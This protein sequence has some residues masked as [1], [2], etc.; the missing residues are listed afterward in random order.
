MEE[1]VDFDTTELDGLAVCQML[2]MGY[3]EDVGEDLVFEGNSYRAKEYVENQFK[4]HNLGHIEHEM[5]SHVSCFT[6]DEIH[7]SSYSIIPNEIATAHSAIISPYL[8]LLSETRLEYLMRVPSLLQ[9]AINSCDLINLRS[10]IDEAYIENCVFKC[11]PLSIVMRG[12]RMLYE[13]YATEMNAVPDFF[14]IYSKPTIEG[15]YICT[16]SY[17]YGTSG[18]QTGLA[19]AQKAHLWNPFA[20]KHIKMDEK[21]LK[22]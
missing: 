19:S 3:F 6:E 22:M 11:E 4:K 20:D 1:I 8:S 13:K 15:R 5:S 18:N 2:E 17:A 14:V 16:K 12:R 21:M 9:C 10:L 7:T